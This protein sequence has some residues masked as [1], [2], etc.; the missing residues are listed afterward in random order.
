MFKLILADPPWKYRN[1]FDNCA[2]WGQA[3]RHYNT[4][5]FN[6]LSALPVIE[7]ANANCILL[8]WCTWP[9]LYDGIN[10]ISKWGFEYVTGFPW[11]K[12]NDISK[13]F[14]GKVNFRVRLGLGFWVKGC[15]EMVLIGKRGNAAPIIDPPLGLLSPNVFHSRKPESIYEYAELFPRPYLELFARQKRDGWSS[16]GNEVSS[17]IELAISA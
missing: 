6:E 8:L 1:S 10:L 14:W 16:W 9:M 17:D 15:S 12:A 3:N 5:T 2:D 4:L 11:I 7:H 13:D